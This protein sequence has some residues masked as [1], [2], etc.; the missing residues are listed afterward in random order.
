MLARVVMLLTLFQLAC[1]EKPDG[2][3]AM[4]TTPNTMDTAGVVYE[5]APQ[6]EGRNA[7]PKFTSVQCTG[8]TDGNTAATVRYQAVDPEGERVRVRVD[9]FV[10]GERIPNETNDSLPARFFEKGDEVVAELEASDGYN[11]V[12]RRCDPAGVGNL[13]PTIQMR[14]MRL[15][16]LDGLQV[17]G[18]D[19]D[20]DPLTWSIEDAPAGMTIDAEGVLHWSGTTQAEAGDYRPRVIAEDPAGE[21]AI[22]EFSV[23]VAAG[24][25]GGKMKRSEA[26]EKGLLGD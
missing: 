10:N 16:S 17:N 14:G 19:P 3:P 2:P 5:D 1:V 7:P 6:V 20:G 22:W 13:P 18:S 26:A 15:D 23:S 9:W 4:P 21:Q 25:E 12:T 8:A 24:V 11:D